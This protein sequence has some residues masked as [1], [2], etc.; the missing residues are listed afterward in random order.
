MPLKHHCLS[1]SFEKH[2]GEY[3]SLARHPI[4]RLQSLKVL[5]GG[6]YADCL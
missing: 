2:V 6:S 5:N 3:L 4:A 1:L